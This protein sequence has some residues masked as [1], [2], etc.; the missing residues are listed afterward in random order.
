MIALRGKIVAACLLATGCSTLQLS[1]AGTP[2][3]PQASF[4]ERLSQADALAPDFAARA[5][6]ALRDAERESSAEA[7]AGQLR[8]AELLTR[9]A[10]VEGERIALA[11]ELAR[12]EQ[13]VARAQSERAKRERARRAAHSDLQLRAAGDQQRSEAIWA[14]GVLARG[15]AGNPSSRERLAAFLHAHAQALLAAA[16]ALAQGGPALPE[17][18][19][20]AL[21]LTAASHAAPA[22]RVA[23]A[24]EALRN[25]ARALGAARA[26]LVG[27]REAQRQDLLEAARE[28]GFNAQLTQAGALLELPGAF[29]AGNAQP[30]PE[31]QRRLRLLRD[32]LL[33]FP[34]GSVAVACAPGGTAAAR[35]RYVAELLADGDSSQR[36]QSTPDPSVPP[37]AV[38]VLLT[39]YGEAALQPTVS[40]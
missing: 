28:R 32:R 12:D 16:A 23:A 35:A 34:R 24:E 33:S 25:A 31:V 15:E 22:A 19:A 36:V 37:D 39:A 29:A 20:A 2:A 4:A 30:R 1:A 10:Q 13:R 7:R 3:H 14:F 27:V 6:L 18:E 38:R 5:R 11:R 8:R 17:A 21:Q 40:P 9:A 26:R